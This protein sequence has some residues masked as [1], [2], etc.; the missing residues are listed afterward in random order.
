MTLYDW[1]QRVEPAEV[2]INPDA[3]QRVLEFIAMEVEQGA[4]PGA[5]LIATRNGQLFVEQ[6]WGTFADTTGP[7]QPLNPSVRVMF[8]SFTKVITATV[9]AMTQQDGLL[10]YDTPVCAYLPEF[11]GGGKESV[12]I[13]HLLTHS[14]GIPNAPH[15][16]LFTEAQWQ[17]T[18]AAVCTHPLEWQPGSRTSY[19]ATSGML[20]AAEAV[21]RVSGNLHWGESAC[22]RLLEPLGMRQTTFD[23]PPEGTLVALTPVPKEFP[24][25]LDEQHFPFLG[26]PAGGAIGSLTDML[27][28]L[29][30][31]LAGGVWDGQVL[32]K[33]ETLTEMHRVQYQP[34]IE[35]A[36]QSGKS[37]AHE[38]WG[39]GWLL[40]GQTQEHWFGFG[41]IASENAFGHAGIDTVIGVA[42][43][44]RDLALAFVT[45][46]SPGSAENTIRLRN[47]VTN[48]VMQAVKI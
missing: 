19:H 45:T 14:A 46:G 24:C 16:P 38:Y 30:L 27:R 5:M 33:P 21:R 11:A 42:D 7:G 10:D 37:P 20:I 15:L 48:L 4:F 44:A 29:N 12:T 8:Y 23:R 26:H 31:Y 32:L 43:P 28:L 34:E 39:L 41:N 6:A 35:Q 1:P 47:T 2:D 40:R 25:P 22:Q 17:V 9:V 3:L 13:R 36:L 18:I